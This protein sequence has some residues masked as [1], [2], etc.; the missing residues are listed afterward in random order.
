MYDLKFS[1]WN[2]YQNSERDRNSNPVLI[3]FQ[4]PNERF[5]RS[6]KDPVAFTPIPHN[7]RSASVA[8]NLW[9]PTSVP[10]TIYKCASLDNR[11]PILQFRII[12]KQQEYTPPSIIQRAFQDIIDEHP[13][14]QLIYTNAAK[15]E[16]GVASATITPTR[17]IC[18]KLNPQNSTLTSIKQGIHD[19][20]CS[21]TCSTTFK[22]GSKVRTEHK[23]VQS[24]EGE[25]GR[26]PRTFTS[27]IGCTTINYGSQVMYNRAGTDSLG[28]PPPSVCG[29][30]SGND[31][32]NDREEMEEV[33]HHTVMKT[34]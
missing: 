15:G 34:D 25:T 3:P 23:K 30:S 32:R 22:F 16:A 18:C 26:E 4:K 2:R 21:T 9:S 13:D 1:G 27:R 24:S 12:N 6:T 7:N 5:V 8:A 20:I 10:L 11:Y 17:T 19:P 33:A 31:W 29:E 28:R 14:F